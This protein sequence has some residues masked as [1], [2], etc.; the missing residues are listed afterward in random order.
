MKV[1]LVLFFILILFALYKTWLE[2]IWAA[3]TA[4][5]LYFAIP[6]IEF[7][8]PEAP[9]QA[10]FWALAAISAIRYIWLFRIDAKKELEAAALS[11]AREA[12]GAVRTSLGDNL[13]LAALRIGRPNEIRGAAL[14]PAEETALD[15]VDRTAPQELTIGIRRAVSGALATAAD[16]GEQ[17]ALRILENMGSST[18]GNM[19]TALESRVPKLVEEQLDAN[20]DKNTL[21]EVENAIEARER[22]RSRAPLAGMGPLGLPLPRGPLSGLLSNPG[23]WMHVMFTVIT[24]IGALYAKYDVYKAMTRFDACILLF[25]PVVAIICAVRDQR[26]VKIFVGAWVFGTIHLAMN[27]ITWW[28]QNGGRA[29]NPGGQGGESNFLGAIIVTI[30]P[31]SF[32]LIVNSKKWRDR[33]IWTTVAAIFVLGILACGSR[34]ALI[35]LIGAGGYWLFHTNKKGFAVGGACIALS[36]FLVVAPD[37]FWERM[38]TIFGEKDKNPWV[39]NAVEPSKHE[40][41]VLWQLAIDIFKDNPVMGIGPRQYVFVS[42]EQTDFTDP[43]AQQRGLQT[44]N[45]WLQLAAEYGIVGIFVWGG[46]FFLS[47]ACYILARRKLKPWPQAAPFSAILLG[48]EA[49]AI[50]NLITATFNSFQWYDYQY[51]HFIFGPLCFQVAKET[52]ERLEW[53]KAAGARETARPPPRYGPPVAEGLD[54]KNIDLS[55]AAPVRVE[56]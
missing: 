31:V 39:L 20:V 37:D 55:N 16:A 3:A 14:G 4:C 26:H 19:K 18:R 43:Y 5:Y 32:G 9:F 41:Q 7:T 2:P 24:Y 40:R 36:C 8:A 1:W 25:I 38:G 44:H 6:P 53:M 29:D 21:L 52:A 34:A 54:L 51:W 33:A 17:E 15:L 28:L 46:A 50:G 22:D 10:G 35:A 30:A 42:A 11:S 45:T 49:G 23:L 12:V 13:V 47:I 48:L 56:G 27:A